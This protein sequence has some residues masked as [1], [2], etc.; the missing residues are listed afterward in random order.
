[1]LGQMQTSGGML[2]VGV[3]GGI[4]I[5]TNYLLIPPNIYTDK[6]LLK[7]EISTFGV[8]KE[9]IAD[10]S[11]EYQLARRQTKLRI[12]SVSVLHQGSADPVP[13]WRTIGSGVVNQDSFTR[14]YCSFCPKI[15]VRV[16]G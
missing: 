15:A 7:V 14:F 12:R 4:E 8:P 16:I 9:R 5:F 3:G 6:F 1:M 13:I 10:G 2:R 11:S